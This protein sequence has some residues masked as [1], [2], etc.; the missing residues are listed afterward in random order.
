MKLQ[1]R[2]VSLQMSGEDVKLLHQELQQLGYTID[3]AE[4]SQ[5]YFGKSTDKIVKIFQK[6]E[7]CF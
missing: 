3:Q 7:C 2:N 6:S 1:G 5:N 4:V